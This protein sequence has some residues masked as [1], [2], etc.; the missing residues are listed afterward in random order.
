MIIQTLIQSLKISVSD[1]SCTGM[2]MFLQRLLAIVAV[3]LLSPILLITALLI[4]LQS[5]GP[6]VFHQVRVGEHGQRFT[7][8]KFRSMY[9]PSDHRFQQPG[10]SDR[11]GI[12][13]KYYNDPRITPIGR[14]I[15]KLSIDELPQLFNVI[16]GDMALIG[17]RPAL[18]SEVDA[19]ESYMLH[20]L[21][22]KPGITGLW[23]VSGRADIGFEEQILLDFKYVEQR[24]FIMDLK[25]LFATVPAVITGRGAY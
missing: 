18:P 6:V 25:I 20:R 16:F 3:L 2:P 1:Y 15:R 19:Y 8:F 4:R 17:P 21:D 12:C 7:M 11:D 10:P 23:Q 5:Q 14:V 13:K 24:S 9:L 22:V